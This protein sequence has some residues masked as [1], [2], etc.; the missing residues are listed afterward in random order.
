MRYPL[1]CRK[2]MTE[3]MTI[4]RKKII[5]KKKRKLKKGKTTSCNI[6]VGKLIQSKC[7]YNWT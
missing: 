3:I 7:E 1:V 4:M 6:H 2:M 5:K